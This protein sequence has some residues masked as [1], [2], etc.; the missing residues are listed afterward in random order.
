[1]GKVSMY[2]GAATLLLVALGLSLWLAARVHL[3]D[4]FDLR[5]QEV[6]VSAAS[7][8][9]E[10]AEQEK[11]DGISEGK[12]GEDAEDFYEPCDPADTGVSHGVDIH[13]GVPME[14]TEQ[15]RAA[16]V[17]KVTKVELSQ[18]AQALA[19]EGHTPQ[20]GDHLIV[21]VT[22]ERKYELKV[23][24]VIDMGGGTYRLSIEV[25]GE[26]EVVA[27]VLLC[28][29][30]VNVEIIDTRRKRIYRLNYNTDEKSYTVT[31]YDMTRLPSAVPH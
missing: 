13:P 17:D 4:W 3:I 14:A 16:G 12:G 5:P 22:A 24:D 23:L 18:E 31:E 10:P 20:P 2:L 21:H 28:D 15:E 29:S 26:T 1:M 9:E 8:G 25:V 7:S 6:G 27:S 11:G 30:R 19:T